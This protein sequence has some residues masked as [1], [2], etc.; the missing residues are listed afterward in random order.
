MFLRTNDVFAYPQ[1]ALHST[2]LPSGTASRIGSARSYNN[3]PDVT[4]K[5]T[6]HAETRHE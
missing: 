4:H 2:P 5:F 6:V 3:H 1:W